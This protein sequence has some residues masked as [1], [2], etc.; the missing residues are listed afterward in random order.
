MTLN[1]IL[2]GDTPVLK[3]GGSVEY[4]FID[5]TPRS[6]LTQGGS[7]CKGPIYK[8]GARSRGWPEGSLFN[9][10]YTEV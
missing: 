7:N 4:S 5:I 10:Y 9:S 6:A 3:N 8:V 2:E 1:C